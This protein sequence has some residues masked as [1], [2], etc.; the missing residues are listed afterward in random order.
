MA[1][2]G[3]R[4]G[5]RDG[6]REWFA[7]AVDLANSADHAGHRAMTLAQIGRLQSAGGEA[8]ATETVARARAEARKLAHGQE[9]DDT[10]DYIAR[11]QARAGDA[12]G[13]IDTAGEIDDRI[14]RAPLLPG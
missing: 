12:K 10:L 2:D 1:A 9:R 3:A 14:N 5:D 6:A 7:A 4:I 11:G 13:A 8:A